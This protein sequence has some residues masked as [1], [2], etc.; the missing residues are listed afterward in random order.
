M[1][2]AATTTE[3]P[4][5]SP[6]AEQQIASL[7]SKYVARLFELLATPQEWNLTTVAALLSLIILWAVRVYMTWATWG[8]LT[9]DSGHEMYIP[10]LLAEGKTLYRDV[11][12]MYTPGA[13]IINGYLFRIFGIHLNVLYWA[14]SL[15]ALGSALL[16]FF[17]G[18]RLASWIAGWTAAA[19]L[20]YEAFEPGIFTFPL[21]YTF[22]ATYGCLTACL[23]VWLIIRAATSRGWVW[24]FA[25]ASVAA[26]A[27]L[28]KPEFGTA[29]YGALAI[30][31]VVRLLRERSWKTL[32]TDILAILPGLAICGL[33]IYWMVSLAGV[34]FITQENIVS[35]PT[36]YFMRTLGSFWLKQTGFSLEFVPVVQA[37]IRT[38]FFVG[39]LLTLTLW[40][41]NK[42]IIFFGAALLAVG[43]A[44]LI[45]L[46]PLPDAALMLFRGVVFP[47]DMILD[48]IVAGAI[49]GWFLLRQWSD[50][51]FAFLLVMT[52]AASV[53]FRI[54]FGMESFGYPV[55]YGGPVILSFL[56]L[57]RPLLKSAG[58]VQWK[59]AQGELI[60]CG[61]CLLAVILMAPRISARSDLVPLTTQRGTM[62]VPREKAATYQVAIDFMREKAALGEPVLSV[63]EDTSLYF[64]SLTHCPVRVFSFTPGVVAPGKMTNDVINQIESAHVRY[65]LWSNRTFFEFG[66]PIFGVD[67][68]RPLGEYLKAHYRFVRPLVPDGKIWNAAIYERIPEPVR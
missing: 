23:F 33:V 28:L 52:F 43:F 14:G 62:L 30:L 49:I 7:I 39:I 35:W 53:S 8:D 1:V 29:S 44:F 67:F 15:S 10:A 61:A 36:S 59:K 63:P 21:P 68:N 26:A 24:M 12:Y 31:V 46:V 38:L 9:V 37:L 32:L 27:L 54:L 17:S 34:D 2:A 11:W 51:V 42:R 65:L 60:F 20:L 57:L 64:L 19:I 50:Q 48:V 3:V 25:G 16:L 56:I 55:F 5:S 18:M 45:R 13:P 6:A 58:R 4:R 40:R 41:S 22:A 47:K 66:V